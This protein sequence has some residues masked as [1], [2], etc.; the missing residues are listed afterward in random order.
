MTATDRRA[1]GYDR[2]PRPLHEESDDLVTTEDLIATDRRAPGHDKKL[3][4]NQ[5]SSSVSRATVIE[6][7]SNRDRGEQRYGGCR[8]NEIHKRAAVTRLVGADVTGINRI[9]EWARE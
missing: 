2:K 5:P 9:T 4:C 1:P 8:C 6:Q 3:D 7:Q